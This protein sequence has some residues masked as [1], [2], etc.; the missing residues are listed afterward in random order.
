[1]TSIVKTRGGRT[2]INNK[3]HTHWVHYTIYLMMNT[4]F[5]EFKGEDLATRFNNC[6]IDNIHNLNIHLSIPTIT[7]EI[8]STDKKTVSLHR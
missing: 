8:V 2:I 1:M 5:R 4:I 3:A 6:L 7:I